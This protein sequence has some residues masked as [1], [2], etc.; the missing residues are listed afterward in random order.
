MHVHDVR[1]LDNL[2]QFKIYVI[3]THTCVTCSCNIF[4]KIYILNNLLIK[5]FFRCLDLGIVTLKNRKFN[6]AMS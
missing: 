6:K 1:K 4:G 3:Q 5:S 2:G